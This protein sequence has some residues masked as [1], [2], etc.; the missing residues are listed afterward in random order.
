MSS[1]NAGG[2]LKRVEP[3]KSYESH[4]T[5]GE[6]L[7][8]GYR[9]TWENRR[10]GGRSVA[11]GTRESYYDVPPI[12]K[13]HWK[14]EIYTYFFFGGISGASYAIAAIAG[15]FGDSGNQRI[16]RVG[17]YLSL[18]AALLSTLLL[19]MDLKRPERFYMM[20]RVLKLR[21]PMSVGTWLL[22]V[23]SAFSGLSAL[24]QAGRDGLFGRG[25]GLGLLLR[26]VPL[27]LIEPLGIPWGLLLSGY[28]GVLLAATAVPLWTKNYLLIGP[29]FLA[30]AM[31]NATAAIA[32][33][34]SLTRGTSQ[35]TFKRLERLDVIAIVTELALITAFKWRLSPTVARPL[36]EGKYA[37]I[38]NVGVIGLGLG[39]PLLLQIKSAFFGGQASRPIVGL[40][41]SLVLMGGLL[42]RYV[43]VKAGKESADD[44]QAT[45]EMASDP[46]TARV[47]ASVASGA[48]GAPGDAGEYKPPVLSVGQ[49]A[50][51]GTVTREPGMRVQPGTA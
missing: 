12:H 48:L 37:W 14:W 39:A 21:S 51:E 27:R 4:T 1:E 42:L 6:T 11:D 41:S 22:A 44:P 15:L 45:F 29:L 38:H 34:L 20:L 43:M 28:T 47:S 26:A 30:T 9:R 2:D 17:R 7:A 33:V 40:A 46:Q 24:V 10:K 13:P 31:S 36:S 35:Q 32:L 25:S 5:V 49:P 8:A 3:E 50:P 19:I 23:F 16:A 18:P